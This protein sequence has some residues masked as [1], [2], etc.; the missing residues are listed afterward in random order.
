MSARRVMPTWLAAYR[1]VALC[2]CVRL[3]GGTGFA[4]AGVPP[5]VWLRRPGYRDQLVRFPGVPHDR[6]SVC[7]TRLLAANA[8]L[9]GLS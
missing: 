6:F 3:S 5:T 1:A 9:H 7:V 4:T 8:R 2:A